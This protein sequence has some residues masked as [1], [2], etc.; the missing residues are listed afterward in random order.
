MQ[1]NWIFLYSY[2]K[3]LRFYFVLSCP[4]CTKIYTF[5][6]H[7]S[8]PCVCVCVSCSRYHLLDLLSFSVYFLA[9]SAIAIPFGAS[10][11]FSSSGSSSSSSSNISSSSW[12]PRGQGFGEWQGTS[13]LMMCVGVM[14]IS[15][16]SCVKT[17]SPI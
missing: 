9:S 2:N 7:S 1:S 6:L 13:P 14:M 16:G 8:L 5:T 12:P 10:L 3:T 4:L 11:A 17:F 15:W